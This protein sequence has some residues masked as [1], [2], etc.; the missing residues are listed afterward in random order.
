MSRLS[1]TV[2]KAISLIATAALTAGLALVGT[3]SSG[4]NAAPLA[5]CVGVSTAFS[6]P[7]TFANLSVTG[8]GT[9]SGNDWKTDNT[10]LTFTHTEESKAC[11]QFQ[12][13]FSSISSGLSLSTTT[14]TG[15]TACEA[16]PWE[17]GATGDRGCF[18]TMDNT[19]KATFSINVSGA[20]NGKSLTYVLSGAGWSSASS[21]GSATVNFTTSSS[22]AAPTPTA[23]ATPTSTLAS[24]V[25]VSTAF[26]TP[27]TFA[28]LS[29]VGN[30]TRSGNNWN[31]DN[32]TLTF[33]HS[34]PSKACQQFQVMFSQISSGLSLS[35]ATGTGSTACES[36]P[37]APGATGDR[38]CFITMDKTGT[39]TF[40]VNISGA[41]TGKSLTYFM[42]GAGWSSASS[43]GS[44]TVNFT[45]STSTATPT[46]GSSVTATPSPTPT[47]SRVPATPLYLTFG[48]D[49]VR[50]NAAGTRAFEGATAS[51]GASTGGRTDRALQ[52]SKPAAGRAWSGVNLLLNETTLRISGSPA[53]S[54]DYY[55][56]NSVNTPV[57]VKVDGAG[58]AEKSV[59]AVPGW[60]RIS[61]DLSTASGYS[62]SANYPILALFPNFGAT[63]SVANSGQ[64]YY[65]DNISNNGGVLA[66]GAIDDGTAPSPTATP[67]ASGTP[68][69]SAT[70]TP[71]AFAGITLD[72]ADKGPLTVGNSWWQ[73]NGNANSV[74]KYVAAGS[75]MT[76]NYTVKDDA[77]VVMPG[78]E[79]TLSTVFS[80]ATYTGATVGVTD[81]NGRVTFTL[82]NT[83][84]DANSENLRSDLTVWSDATGIEVKGDFVP[85]I[86]SAGTGACYSK[87][88]GLCGRDRVWT[89]VVSST[90]P[91]PSAT[92]TGPPA[93]ESYACA[94]DP[95]Q[96]C[97]PVSNI[98][99]ASEG[100]AKA[101]TAGA[102]ALDG[103]KTVTFTYTSSALDA[104][105]QLTVDLFNFSD[106]LTSFMPTTGCSPSGGAKQCTIAL[107][108]SGSATFTVAFTGNG[109][110]ASFRYHIVGPTYGSA[111]VAASFVGGTGATAT[112]TPTSTVVD[113]CATSSVS[114]EDSIDVGV[115]KISVLGNTGKTGNLL[116]S[117]NTDLTVTV[118]DAANPCKVV[119]VAFSGMSSDWTLDIPSSS[120]V[121]STLPST[122]GCLAADAA[123]QTCR[124]RLSDAGLATFHLTVGNVLGKTFGYKI[125]GPAAF[126]TETVTVSF[127]GIA[128]TPTP[129]PTGTPTLLP[130]TPIYLTFGLGDTRGNATTGIDGAFEGAIA[131]VGDSIDGR[132]DRALK[133]IKPAESETARAWSGV[134]ILTKETALRISGGSAV[135]FD[136][137]SPNS[138]DVP[139]L[140]KFDGAGAT[141]KVATA[142]PGWSRIS[143]DM[144]SAVGYSSTANY[145][146]LA[147]FPNFDGDVG[148]VANSGQAYYI[149]NV[150]VN[151]GVL[152]D[153]AV[154]ALPAVAPDAPTGVSVKGL[155]ATTALISWTAPAEN[156][157]SP[158]TGYTYT[159]KNNGTAV[160]GKSGTVTG[161][162]VTVT[163][164]VASGSKYSVSVTAT[165]AAGTSAQSSS[166]GT[167]AIAATAGAAPA[168]PASVKAAAGNATAT[169]TWV[170]AVNKG[171]S[172]TGYSIAVKSGSTLVKT[173]TAAPAAAGITITG[174]TN[175]VAYTFVVTAQSAA[176]NTSALATVA[177]TPA[178]VPGA[179]TDVV[180][181]RGSKNATVTW[182]T[183]ANGGSAITGYTVTYTSEL[184][185]VKTKTAAATANSVVV[186][187]LVNGTE[188]TISVTAKNAKGTSPAS[189]EVTVTPSTTPGGPATVTG[190]KGDTQVSL[191]WAVPTVTGGAPITGYTVVV[192]SGTSE[193]KRVTSTTNSLVV[194]GLT[195]GTAYT[196]AVFATNL[197]G[198]GTV[199]T[200]SAVTPSTTP[201]TVSTVSS[202]KGSAAGA[203]TVTFSV[204]TT[205]NTGGSVITGYTVKAYKVSDGSFFKSVTVKTGTAAFTGLTK[206][207]YN[208]TVTATNA[209][210]VGTA[211]AK[212]ASVTTS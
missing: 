167:V 177:V 200:S 65:F 45:T 142:V 140:V 184:G 117:T 23:S 182:T 53:I 21:G 134:N 158:I 84:T 139:V 189:S 72:A 154:D 135:S 30:G 83:N 9:R 102:V 79:V 50:G 153:G 32:T 163:G 26:G 138:I 14:G 144:S 145:P 172:L 166:F 204:L 136:F 100:A 194:T 29:V 199:K 36:G 17:P 196:F 131:T 104:G 15:S 62:A 155:T 121:N 187:S 185:V 46:P 169:L 49:D 110:G 197:V 74:V 165:N 126:S 120:R 132:T 178:T 186:T 82:V 137:Y 112:P 141:Q 90:A 175:G 54:F 24:C 202:V 58:G 78:V 193:V 99:V 176:G 195:N 150:S 67:T 111:N 127:E 68:T 159:V 47:P 143:V 43:G 180:A 118:N 86:S 115:D 129:T 152:A 10:I 116:K 3:V 35:T 174:L 164:L 183:P 160:P 8:N 114:T 52:V 119:V 103:G 92:P 149:D 98:T 191:V 12:V 69:A 48:A 28:N 211:T 123:F 61:V 124:I 76:L 107:N 91:D 113:S 42:S 205:A 2:R 16:G 59:M 81:A 1:V 208:F 198:N 146:T 212:L 51:V 44:A 34:E 173:V 109:D 130:A 25:G 77:G 203:A 11:Q 56:P 122:L 7:K 66:D 168:A 101:I 207:T 19:G 37:W 33:T 108:S 206:G 210:G 38:G 6:T 106:G 156:G 13:M 20:A 181:T 40:S 161:T 75:T 88:N 85:Y 4:A 93:A 5:S 39:A 31:T 125:I 128:T 171:S 96:V 162:S 179:P 157:G 105:K 95:T 57:L 18:I 201:G 71:A 60:S 192:K 80:R 97:A 209:N 133:L 170:T 87:D 27:K 148:A 70:P 151:G 188:Y 55:S 41:A 147:L 190:V 22:T 73:E 63:T 94:A 64:T 89:H